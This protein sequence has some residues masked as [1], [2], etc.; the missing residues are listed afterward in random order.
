M[1]DIVRS[2]DGAS[3]LLRMVTHGHVVSLIGALMCWDYHSMD[4]PQHSMELE[5]QVFTITSNIEECND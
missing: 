5:F 3:R 4:Q 1:Q 2:S